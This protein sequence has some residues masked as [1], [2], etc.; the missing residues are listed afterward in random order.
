MSSTSN[1]ALRATRRPNGGTQT[2]HTDAVAGI[3][4]AETDWSIQAA[5]AVPA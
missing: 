1:A 3:L 4:A 5:A 2:P